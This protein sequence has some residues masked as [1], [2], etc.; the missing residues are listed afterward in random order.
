MPEAQSNPSKLSKPVTVKPAQSN[1]ST[2][3]DMAP[4]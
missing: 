2:V 3:P 4:P 1:L